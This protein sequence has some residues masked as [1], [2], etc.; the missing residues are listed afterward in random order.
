M[1]DWNALPGCYDF[2]H[3]NG[4]KDWGRIAATQPVAVIL[5]ATDGRGV[6]PL[7]E[8]DRRE[9]AARGIPVLWYPYL[10]PTDTDTAIERALEVVGDPSLPPALDWEAAGVKAAI[11]ERWIAR[12]EAEARPG[13][14]YYGLAPPDKVTTTIARWPRWYP[15]YPGSASAAPRLP[16]WDGRMPADWRKQWL[17]WQWSETGRVPGVSGDADMDRLA[18]SAAD[19]LTWYR[20]GQLPATDTPLVTPPSVSAA[21]ARALRLNMTGDDVLGLQLQLCGKGY[22]VAKD[23]YFG[24]ATRKAVV[25]FQQANRLPADGV[26][27]PVT[28]KAL[29][30]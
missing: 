19:F 29:A 27:G 12:C 10:E 30:A 2:S 28:L 21:V 3:W 16:P 23:G 1:T 14:C 8:A 17:V 25:T 22:Q 9:A 15:Q 18:C 7:F 13:L 20:T 26:A 6:D 4:P 24:P 5:K 11:V